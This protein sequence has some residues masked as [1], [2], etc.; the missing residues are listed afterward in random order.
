MNCHDFTTPIKLKLLEKL[1]EILPGDLVRRATL[2]QRHDGG[3]GRPPRLPRGHRQ[4]RVPLL[5]RRLPR[6]ERACRKS[7]ADEARL[8]LRRGRRAS[9][10]CRAR[11]PTARWFKKPDG[12]I[13]TDA[14]LAFYDE[15]MREATTGQV[16]AIVLEPIQ[17]WAGSIFPPGRFLS[18][19]APLV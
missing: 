10:C 17:G 11:T 4:A 3:R 14:Y 6:Q 15:F 13:D 5:L 12:T 8:R 2:R 7:G 1:K 18:Q 19:A 16:A 9:T